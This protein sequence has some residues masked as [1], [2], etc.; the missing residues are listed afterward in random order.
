MAVVFVLKYNDSPFDSSNKQAMNKIQAIRGMNDCLPSESDGW[1]MLEETIH[2]VARLFSYREIRTP[3]VEELALFKRSVGEITDIVEKEMYQFTD[4]LNDQVLA[5]RPEGTA[6]CVRAV[7][8][9]HLLYHA[10][11]RLWYMGPM[12][13][14][15]RPQKGRYRQFHQ[16]GVEALGFPEPTIE[17]EQIL[18]L[19]QLWKNLGLKHLRLEINTIGD[20]H[21]RQIFR[22]HLIAYFEAYQSD[23]D[24]DSQR[25]LY[26]NPLR[27]LD[28]KTQSLKN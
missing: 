23:L 17:V 25:R 3:I 22:E 12:F 21:E 14:H 1:Q 11:P 20:G 2:D 18:M 4:H 13:R 26:K 24:E 8:E 7:L 16:F 15:E 10:T 28:S 6:G 9:H 27:I 5:L 19:Q